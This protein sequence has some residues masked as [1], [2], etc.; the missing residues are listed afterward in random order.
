MIRTKRHKIFYAKKESAVSEVIGSVMLIT[1][2]VIAVSIVGVVLWSQ[3]PSAKIPALS[4][5]IVSQSCNVIVSHNG[6]DML[7]QQAFKIL[8]DGT[9]ETANFTKNGNPVWTSWGIGDTLT[10]TSTPCPPIPQNVQIIYTGGNGALVLSS[11]YFGTQLSGNATTT[12]TPTPTPTPAPAPTVSGITPSSAISGTIVSITNLAGTNFVNGATVN[13]TRA[14]YSDISG[15]GV[16]FVSSTQ[17][18]CTFNLAGAAPGQWNVVVTN[19]DFQSGTGSNLFTVS[20][21]LAPTVST[22]TP[23]TGNRGWPV[24]ITNLAGN[25]FVS[26]AIVKLV[27]N[28]AG[29]DVAAYNVFVVSPT[30]I[31]CN[32]NLL[33]VN[34]GIWN[35]TVQNPSSDPGTLKN[36]FTVNSL[37]PTI[38]GNSV[39]PTGNPGQLVTITNLP[40]TNYQP[41][42]LVDYYQGGTRINLTNVNVVSTTQM[43][44]TLQIPANAPTGAYNIMVTNT[45]GK[46]GTRTSAFTVPMVTGITPN[47]Y[48]SGWTVSIT[49]LAGNKFKDGATVKLVNASAGP[50]I[51][52]TNVVV[53]S[54][55]QITCTF[56]LTGAP[57]ARRNV[58]VTNPDGETGTLSNG[59]TI[60]SNA[61]TLT[62]RAPTNSNRG[63][64]VGVTLTGTGFQ[65]SPA[66]RL[67]RSG[68]SDVY[69]YG[70]TAGSPTQITCTFDLNGVTSGAWNILVT[71][72]DGQSS[73]T[74]T[75]TVNAPTP[76]FTS[77]TPATG[78]HGT[79]VP[80]TIVGTGFQPGATVTYTR[81][82]TTISFT[83]VSVTA[84]QITGN[85]VIPPGATLGLYGVTITNTDGTTVTSAN[86]F[87]VT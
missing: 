35:V 15:S 49:N 79:T 83:V 77:N 69:A 72:V 47:T 50:D 87:T 7:E 23:N 81:A 46:S 37:A 52:A 8:V 60:T 19:P 48:V 38:T 54:A 58:T 80:I 75:F 85:L 2:V 29:P 9:D 27:N 13:L 25:N 68:Y 43:S 10:Y 24:T 21:T 14:G 67:T 39:P 1:I 78:V 30:M 82:P 11:G 3:P 73:G 71:N 32:F 36:G 84:T 74:M 6:G 12:P 28:T 17:L 76:T 53:V 63:W 45:D 55:N 59:F 44:G 18:T 16:G 33:G 70:V 22:I 62:V 5:G 64:P 66:V 56:D 31:T 26:G 34:Q 65:P 51:T 41:G 20:P 86:R 57:A 4:A 42:A 61:P 40:G